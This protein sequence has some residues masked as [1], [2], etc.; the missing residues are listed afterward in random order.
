MNDAAS[1][2][3]DNSGNTTPRPGN[4]TL[5]YVLAA[6]TLGACFGNMFLSGK[7]KSVMNIKVR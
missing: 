7:M 3:G 2:T 4:S 5:A 1:A 6:I